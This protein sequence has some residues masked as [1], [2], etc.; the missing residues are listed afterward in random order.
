MIRKHHF[1]E[2][3][4]WQEGMQ[5]VRNVYAY[6]GKLPD[7]ERFGFTSQMNRCVLSLP[8]NIAEGSG[9][10]ETEF[11]RFLRISLSSSF[12]LETLLEL[13]NDLFLS[14]PEQIMLDLKSFQNKTKAFINSIK[15]HIDD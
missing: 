8:T 13:S 1:K 2:L 11:Y 3:G 6:S 7:S 12:E 14:V 4:I 10:T 15:Q 9:R 5:P